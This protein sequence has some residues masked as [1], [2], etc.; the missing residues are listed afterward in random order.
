MVVIIAIGRHPGTRMPGDT[1]TLGLISGPI[2]PHGQAG[3]RHCGGFVKHFIR[4]VPTCPTD[5][6]VRHADV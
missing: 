6:V 5:K 1:N 3:G 4:C 2:F